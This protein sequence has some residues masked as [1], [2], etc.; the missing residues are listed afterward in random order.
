MEIKKAVDLDL[1]NEADAEQ[2]SNSPRQVMSISPT[3]IDPDPDSMTVDAKDVMLTPRVLDQSAYDSLSNALGAQIEKAGEI[4]SELCSR[5]EQAKDERAQATKSSA[6]LQERLRVS[7]RMLKAFQSQI[8]SVQECLS[9]LGTTKEEADKTSTKLTER[10]SDVETSFRQASK[11]FEKNIE[12]AFDKR[13]K[14]FEEQLTRREAAVESM[15]DQVATSRQR[16]ETVIVESQERITNLV[17]DT[18]KRV[19]EIHDGAQGYIQSLTGET[20]T[21]VD[22]LLKDSQ[23]QMEELIS[24]NEGRIEPLVAESKKQVQSL[25]DK[26]RQRVEALAG[27][28][29]G[30]T[31]KLISDTESRVETLQSKSKERAETLQNDA[32]NSAD[33]MMAEVRR[34]MESITKLVEEAERTA[35]DTAMKS[36]KA[37]E[38]VEKTG[39]EM[40]QIMVQADQTRKMLD[41]DLLKAVQATDDIADRSEKICRTVRAGKDELESAAARLEYCTTRIEE[42]DKKREVLEKTRLTLTKVLERLKPWE[43]LLKSTDSSQ[44]EGPHTLLQ[45]LDR[46]RG[47]LSEDAAR[48]SFTMR[49][50]AD[51]L[52]GLVNTG[53]DQSP[54]ATP[55]V[56]SD[57][58]IEPRDAKNAQ[59]EI[60]T[61][62]KTPSKPSPA[63]SDSISAASIKEK[64]N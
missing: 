54:A 12:E 5:F 44:G 53:R 21:A 16:M 30:R 22:T 49:Q 4:L 33:I 31:Q 28:A 57:V 61:T 56:K 23:T 52:Q 10:I 14:R 26:T 34:S 60:T 62:V 29:K 41:K 24:R 64:P 51:N 13:L 55:A 46:V 47:G 18:E 15:V 17:T 38:H 45:V 9:T 27:E 36:A 59:P 11:R 63:T 8:D 42:A 48:L 7:A 3:D 37:S 1:S 20:K 2:V 40:L 39:A 25:L 35:A 43:E 19:S 58:M 32:T 50:L 6:S